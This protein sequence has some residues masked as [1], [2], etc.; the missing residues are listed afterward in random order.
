MCIDLSTTHSPKT[1]PYIAPNFAF[2]IFLSQLTFMNF[3]F[4]SVLPFVPLYF[5]SFPFLFLFY[6]I[7]ILFTSSS[8]PSP[9]QLF[10]SSSLN[11]FT[12]STPSPFP[13]LHL[14]HAFTSSSLLF[15]TFSPLQAFTSSSLNPLTSSSLC[16]HQFTPLPFHFFSSSFLIP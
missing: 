13:P 14:F 7:I 2:P 6:Y 4:F 1:N 10:L 15:F 16:L 8:L 11:L 9:L 3:I 12:S 5:L